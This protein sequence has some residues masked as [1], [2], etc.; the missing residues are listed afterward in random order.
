MCLPLRTIK[1]DTSDSLSLEWML[2]IKNYKLTLDKTRCTGCQICTLACPK[3]AIRTE[4]QRNAPGEKVQ[5][6]RIDI[7]LGKCNFCGICDILC[8]FGAIKLAID[9]KHMLSVVDKKSFPTLARKIQVNSQKFTGDLAEAKE[10]CP[11]GLI[12]ATYLTSDGKPVQDPQMLDEPERSWVHSNIQIDTE[13]C[14]CCKMCE[15]KLPLGAVQVHKFLSGK[16]TIHQSKCPLNCTDCIDVC[17][18]PGTLSTL[19]ADDKVYVNEAFCVYCG[20]CKNVCPIE[21][22]LEV[23]RTRINHSSIHSGA[24]NK[25]LERLTSSTNMTKELKTKGSARARESVMRRMRLEVEQRA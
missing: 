5:K 22:A 1:K 19:K 15:T 17:P 4:R 7:D 21:D 24:W 23:K 2:Q 9:G 25:A 18:I 16:I 11:L 12:N 3:Q 20:A 8:P 13:H 6:V 14:P 10:A